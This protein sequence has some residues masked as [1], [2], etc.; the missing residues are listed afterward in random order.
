[1]SC[2]SMADEVINLLRKKEGTTA[3]LNASAEQA[4]RQMDWSTARELC[5]QS[6]QLCSN[7]ISVD[8]EECRAIAQMY[9]GAVYHSMGDLEEAENCYRQSADTFSIMDRDDSRWNEAV[10]QY[11]LGLLAQSHGDL[12]QAQR[13]YHQSLHLFRYLGKRTVDVRLVEHSVSQ[14]IKSL[15]FLRRQTQKSQE[16]LD[17]VPI[18]GTTAAGEPILAI[19]VGPEDVSLNRISLRDRNCKVKKILEAVKDDAFELKP[20]SIY[21]AL[22]VKGE[23]MNKADI[24]DGDYVIF[25]QQPDVAPGDIVAVRTDDPYGSSTTVKRFYRRGKTILLKAENPEYQP[26]V[27]IFQAS[28]PTIV[29]LGKAVAVASPLKGTTALWQ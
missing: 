23:S 16:R 5:E 28:D 10:A 13:L 17:S 19:E 18:I 21:F 4:R 15:E 26:Q 27:Q 7:M 9:L 2:Q 25:R 29:I 20:N 12:Y 11:A 3:E 6:L 22:R 8:A 24:E 14:R 1:M